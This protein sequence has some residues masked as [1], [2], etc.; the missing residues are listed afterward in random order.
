MVKKI[1][2]EEVRKLAMKNYNRGGDCVVEYWEDADIQE[3]ID[4]GMITSAQWLKSFHSF[5]AVRRDTQNT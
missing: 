4:D 1:T 5:D 3:A 2:V